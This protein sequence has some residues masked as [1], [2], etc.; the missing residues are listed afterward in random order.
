MGY[1]PPWGDVAHDP[2]VAV[3]R[4]AVTTFPSRADQNDLIERLLRSVLSVPGDAVAG[5]CLLSTPVRAG[6]RVGR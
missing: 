6:D 4:H 1:V 3:T 2:G 5:A